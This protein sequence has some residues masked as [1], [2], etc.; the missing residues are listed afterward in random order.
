MNQLNEAELEYEGLSE[1]RMMDRQLEAAVK[2]LHVIAIMHEGDPNF[3]ASIAIDAL[4]EMEI[5][6]YLYEQFTVEYD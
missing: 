1:E 6:G 5:Y 2:A 3:M 4:K